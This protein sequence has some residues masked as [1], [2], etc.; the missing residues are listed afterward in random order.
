METC[1]V[2]NANQAILCIVLTAATVHIVADNSTK[3]AADHHRHSTKSIVS[4]PQ[5]LITLIA[6]GLPH[7][8]STMRK[9]ETLSAG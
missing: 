3:L 5:S 8:P 7:R 6:D 9:P 2:S 1:S 4:L